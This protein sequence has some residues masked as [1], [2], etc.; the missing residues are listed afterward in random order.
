MYFTFAIWWC[1]TQPEPNQ[2]T[3]KK[4]AIC[5]WNLNSL[6]AHN[7]AKLV[8]L[9]AYNS[10]HKFDIICLW[11]TYLDSKILIDDRNLEIPGYNLVRSDH[12]SNKN[13][14]GVCIY[15]KSYL[16]L[17]TIDIN[18]LVECVKFELMV[19]DKLCNF[20]ALYRSP[21]QLQ[22][23]LKF[24]WQHLYSNPQPLIS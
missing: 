12:L 8:L 1:W 20:I 22:H 11:E 7:L 18:Y 2:N 17:R 19:G 3:A 6:V 5:H 9:K 23:Q 4:I 15:C 10:I 24:K 21:S 13:R 14:G 16:P